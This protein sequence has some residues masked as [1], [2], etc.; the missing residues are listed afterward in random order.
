VNGNNTTEHSSSTSQQVVC[1]L[2][3]CLLPC[4]LQACSSVP[5][6]NQAVLCCRLPLLLLVLLQ[7]LS[8]LALPLLL[9]LLLALLLT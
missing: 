4:K 9:L 1:Q 6:I 8:P 7:L 2:H 3:W 5:A